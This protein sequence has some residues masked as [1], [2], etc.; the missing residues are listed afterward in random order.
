MRDSDNT[1]KE[2]ILNAAAKLFSERG[3]DGT[4]VSEIARKAEVNKALIY[5]YFQ[6]KADI[7]DNLVQFLL[8][9]VA[10][11]T[12]DYIY[13]TI[14]K[15]RQQK[16]WSSNLTGST[17]RIKLRLHTLWTALISIMQRY[18]TMRWSTGKLSGSLCWNR[19]RKTKT[20]MIYSKCWTILGTV[21]TNCTRAL[22]APKKNLLIPMI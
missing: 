21:R 2:R 10:G 11:I 16:L 1:A 5:Y 22:S 13:P 14:E 12:I 8:E 6:N 20:A 17:L 3:F 4:T 15:W 18:L 9:N 19:S 7:L